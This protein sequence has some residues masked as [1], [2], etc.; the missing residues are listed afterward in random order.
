MGSGLHLELDLVCG[1]VGGIT[2]VEII[3]GRVNRLHI[4]K[5]VTL[6]RNVHDIHSAAQ[7]IDLPL[8][9]A[10]TAASFSNGIRWTINSVVVSQ[11]PYHSHLLIV[12][13]L[14]FPHRKLRAGKPTSL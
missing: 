6:G 9:S 13:L 14:G 12:S 10:G 5:D 11:E 4:P 8:T 2:H 1:D 7:I 3:T